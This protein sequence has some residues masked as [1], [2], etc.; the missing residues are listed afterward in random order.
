[1][2]NTFM[3]KQSFSEMKNSR[4][5]YHYLFWAT[6]ILS[7]FVDQ[8]GNLP[9]IGW[10]HLIGIS[11]LRCGVLIFL[12]YFNLNYLIPKY[13]TNKNYW[14]YTIWVIMSMLA[15]TIF[16]GGYSYYIT[17]YISKEADHTGVSTG[18]VLLYILFDNL[19]VAGRYIFTSFLLKLSVDWYDQQENLNKAQIEVLKAEMNY[20]KAQINPHFLFNTLNN[21]YGLTLKK[22]DAAPEMVLKL[23]NMLYESD[24]MYVPLEKD[25]NNI[26]NYIAIEKMRQGNNA[27]I[28][29]QCI[30]S[31]SSLKIIPHL[32]LPL[33]ENS[34]K[35]GVNQIIN[36]AFVSIKL[37]I[38]GNSIDF[39]ISNNKS[40]KK[41]LSE[42]KKV[43]LA[44]LKKRLDL[45][46][47]G[48]HRLIVAE[49]EKL[50]NV[51]LHIV[52]I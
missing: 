42:G 45:F 46:F 25:V 11:F 41:K 10:K 4:H 15:F 19:L 39:N 17:K 18:K 44:N 36:G 38:K 27:A 34:F 20:L 28:D 37:S 3:P 49:D 8:I 2:G 43:G 23:S 51:S 29:F 12:V 24:E 14:K 33:I 21:L 52:K 7:Y 47:P 6:L 5:L 30:G 1:M 35:H 31:I 16:H 48:R 22:S 13:Y 26:V 40:A 50:Y 32:F 9:S